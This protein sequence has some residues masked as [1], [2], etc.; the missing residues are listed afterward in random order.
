MSDDNKDLPKDRDKILSK[1]ETRDEPELSFGEDDTSESKSYRISKKVI[2]YFKDVMDQ[3]NLTPKEFFNAIASDIQKNEILEHSSGISNEMRRNFDTDV[4]RLKEA[5][6]S[7][8]AIFNS[9]MKSI[10]VEKDKWLQEK[11]IL[12]SENNLMEKGLKEAKNTIQSLNDSLTSV[13]NELDSKIADKESIIK[14]KDERIADK[15]S[16]IVT[17]ENDL[18]AL[19]TSFDEEKNNLNNRIVELLNEIKQFEPIKEEKEKLEKE[20]TTNKDNVEKLKER[21]E[22]YKDKHQSEMNNLIAK[23]EIEVKTAMVD[24]ESRIRNDLN[25]ALEEYRAENRNLYER[26]DKLREDNSELSK[27]NTRIKEKVLTVVDENERLKK[28]IEQLKKKR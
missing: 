13:R 1:D 9:Q 27:E 28:E 4:R 10:L 17:L 16:R 2:A 12:T 5:T 23:H 21:L 3:K 22:Y 6:D 7:I 15:D 14:E 20:V 26:L 11:D 25:A 19:K 24:T 8:N 18:T